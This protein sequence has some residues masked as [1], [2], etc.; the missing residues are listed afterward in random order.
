M[1]HPVGPLPPSVYWRRRLVLFGAPLLI[2][3]TIAVAL[4]GGGGGATPTAASTSTSS[5]AATTSA[6]P[7]PTTSAAATTTHP[8]SIRPTTTAAAPATVTACTK[9][10]LK[11]SAASDAASYPAGAQP[12]LSL[13]VVNAGPAPCIQDLADSQIELRVYAGSARVWGS[14]DCQVQPGTSPQ[15][16]PVGQTIRRSI[17]WSG[18]S[19]QPGCAG[20]RQRVP[21][22]TYTLYPLLGG[23]QGKASQFVLAG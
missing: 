10:Q 14:H 15:R 22:G 19:S 2:L 16:L 5:A 17:Q 13:V 23:V 8:A 6:A 11:V 20:T 9:A 4:V 7:T 18:L 1:L 12:D 21:A 3:L